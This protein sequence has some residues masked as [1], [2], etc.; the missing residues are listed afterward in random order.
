MPST[1]T[2]WTSF[3]TFSYLPPGLQPHQGGSSIFH[4]GSWT[5]RTRH[6]QTAGPAPPW[7]AS[8]WVTLAS[9]VQGGPPDFR[10]PSPPAKTLPFIPAAF[11]RPVPLAR[12]HLDAPPPPTGDV[13]RSVPSLLA[14]HRHRTPSPHTPAASAKKPPPPPAFNSLFP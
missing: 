8:P 4:Q 5:S 2:P 7:P 12:Y 3:S 11:T 14:L 9:I 13:F 1:P 6:Q 10:E